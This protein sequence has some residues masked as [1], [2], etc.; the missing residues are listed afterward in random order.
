MSH[1][2][3]QK[4]AHRDSPEA[5]PG[6]PAAPATLPTF[7]T[8]L[9]GRER[10]LTTVRQLLDHP[11]ARLLTLTGPGGVGKTR[12]A[13][14]AARDAAEYFADG[15]LFVS[16]AAIRDRELVAP[17]LARA[18][19]V[20]EEGQ[21]PLF[22]RLAQRLHERE[23]LLVL[24][25]FEQVI[26]AA[27]LLLDLLQRCARLKI[28]V[29]SRHVLRVRGEHV[30]TVPPLDVPHLDRVIPGDLRANTLARH[31]SVS[32]FLTYA[33]SARPGYEPADEEAVAIARLCAHLGGVPLA[34]ELAAARLRHLSPQTLLARLEEARSQPALR[35]PGPGSRD[36][37][38]RHQTLWRTMQW[39]Y[40]LLEQEERQLFRRLSV[41][42]GPFTLHA[43][44]A[45]LQAWRQESDGDGPS[46]ATVEAS[47]GVAFTVE[48]STIE[49][50]ASLVDKSLLQQQG[51][52]QRTRFG[53]LTPV[54]DF[55]WAHC[56]AS[57]EE[58]VAYEAFTTHFLE[59]AEEAAP[60]LLSGEQLARL[61]R[62]ERDYENLQAALRWTLEQ[63]DAEKSLRLAN[64]LWRFWVMRGYLSD[65]RFLDQA[66]SLA[67]PQHAEL[68]AWAL[69]RS[70]MLA[71]YQ[72]DYEDAIPRLRRALDLFRELGNEAGE[73][74]A[75]TYLGRMTHA[76][77]A[78]EATEE[79]RPFLLKAE[80]MHR[81]LGNTSELATTLHGLGRVT[82]TLGE[83]DEARAYAHDALRLRREQGNQ[84]GVAVTL[85]LAAT[86]A[87]AQEAYALARE[88]A[89]E[90]REL[91]QSFSNPYGV[92]AVDTLLGRI[93]L[94]QGHAA[95][96]R[97]LFQSALVASRD[98][99]H[100]RNVGTALTGLGA[101]ALREKQFDRAQA[102]LDEALDAAFSA[103]D[104]ALIVLVLET[105]AEAAL[106]RE[107]FAAAARCL[108]A[109]AAVR[110]ARQVP[111]W[112]CRRRK[113]HRLRQAVREA[114]DDDAFA[115]AW[116]QGPA[117]HLAGQLDVEAA[118]LPPDGKGPPSRDGAGDFDLTPREL[119]VLEL[120]AQ[121]LTDKEVAEQLV[122]S[123]RTVQGH[124]RSIYGKLEVHS[125]TA[126]ARIALEHDLLT[127]DA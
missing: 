29:T 22:E 94:A 45:V 107:E 104:V 52:E 98:V 11:H 40:D 118:P 19:G 117:L 46:P 71:H 24:D 49:G 30:F 85:L 48:A 110:D 89:K 63:Q 99:S 28:L 13:V 97:E 21:R 37:P 108:G 88:L 51:G 93:A 87:Y 65:R 41:F 64:A 47:T 3:D 57:G 66:L 72:T 10:E 91:F 18:L 86:I 38:E 77:G 50:V 100:H 95:E 109:A 103:S 20:R 31:A 68:Q 4:P 84:W 6:T 60:H 67:G 112:P 33:R 74:T 14:R 61:A 81:Q 124:L 92:A 5:A 78:G 58:T 83:Y 115:D 101:L 62:L 76:G 116:R 43:A 113:V 35:L 56:Q 120:V 122:I 106:L 53:M 80:A 44:E 126:A 7:L 114:L 90:N 59:L 2:Q 8:P 15:V 9:I 123:P 75:L 82:F 96:A 16:L 111:L 34:L 1:T 36:M 69:C 70:A 127:D 42:A 125:R 54:R 102:F 25:N 39:S 79:A 23:K 119:D 27:P 105:L 121:G 26:E 55:A 32:L 17:A 12:L 73:A